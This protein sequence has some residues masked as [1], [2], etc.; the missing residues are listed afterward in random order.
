MKKEKEKTLPEVIEEN[1]FNVQI[2]MPIED[3]IVLNGVLFEAVELYPTDERQSSLYSINSVI[4]EVN[5]N[6]KLSN[7]MNTIALKMEEDKFKLLPP[8]VQK[9]LKNARSYRN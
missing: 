9:E 7:M 8:E 4:Q 1:T 5:K 3:L 6:S 2:T